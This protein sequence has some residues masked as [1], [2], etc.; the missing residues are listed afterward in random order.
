VLE[1]LLPGCSEREL[2]EAEQ[3]HIDRLRS[4]TPE[5]G[6]NMHPAIFSKIARTT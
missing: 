5:L 4:R 2:R 6:F 1:K 3:R